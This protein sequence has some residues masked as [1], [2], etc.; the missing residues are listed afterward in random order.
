MIFPCISPRWPAGPAH[1][2]IRLFGALALQFSSAVAANSPAVVGPRVGDFEIHPALEIQLVAAEPLLASPV[3]MAFDEAGRLFVAEMRDYP[4]LNEKLLGR[5]SILEDT[6][7]DGRFDR[8]RVFADQLAWPSGIACYNG[9]VFVASTP[10]LIYL[11]DTDGDGRADVR[12][13]VF[14][15]FGKSVPTPGAD[16][17]FN[18]FAWGL[19]NRFYGST[20]ANGGRVLRAGTSD[21]PKE[22]K[23]LDFSFDP[24]ALTL[25][26]ETGTGQYGLTFDDFG[27]R[28]LTNN[29]RHLIMAM[30]DYRYATRNPHFDLPPALLDIPVDGPAAEVFRISPEEEWRVIRTQWRVAGKVVGMIEGGGRSSGY[31]TSACGV[32]IYR[33]DALPAEFYGNAFVAEPTGNLVHRKILSPNG[34]PMAGRRATGEEK[35]EVLRSRDQLFRPVAFANGP[36][37]ALYLIDMHRQLIEIAS[38]LPAGVREKVD[39]YGGRDTGRIYRIAARGRGPQRLP[40][41]ADRPTSDLVAL[42]EARNA[43]SRETAARLIFERQDRTAVAA[44]ERLAQRANQAGTRVLALSVLDGLGA[45]APKH[46]LPALADPQSEVRE[47]AVKLAERFAAAGAVIPAAVDL[48][49][50]LRTHLLRLADDPA[51][52]VRYQLAFSIGELEPGAD[53]DAALL[54]IAV[55]SRG[56]RWL[57][58]ACLTAMNRN[59]YTLFRRVIT[60]AL[61]LEQAAGVNLVAQMLGIL[62]SRGQPEERPAVIDFLAG[63]Q[64]E[65]TQMKLVSAYQAGLKRQNRL[66]READPEGK[67]AGVLVAAAAR[68][69]DVTADAA[70]RVTAIRLAALSPI[71]G[72][73]LF[74]ELLRPAEP[75]QIQAEAIAALALRPTPALAAELTRRWTEFTAPVRQQAL[76]LLIAQPARMLVLLDAVRQ[77]KIQRSDLTASQIQYLKNH[78]DRQVQAEA[79]AVFAATAGNRQAV[80]DRFQGA[81]TLT[82]DFARGREVFRTQCIACHRLEGVG[83]DLGTDLRGV[84]NRGKEGILI[85]ILDPNRKVD[86]TYLFYEIVTRKGDVV[87]GAVVDETPA[88]ITIRQPQGDQTV[89]M[90]A[91]LKSMKANAQSLM[92]EGLE[93]AISVQDM[94]D[95]LEY[96][97]HVP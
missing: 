30:Y 85:D 87:M 12:K 33:G 95:L 53:A 77:Q 83:V 72:N 48:R 8:S 11:R 49:Q 67:L 25:R 61:L 35:T 59:A 36:D 97:L 14:T 65:P 45:L 22:M 60:D 70:V 40:N 47:F 76:K 52:R 37:G 39:V 57:E 17:V 3:A 28:Y 68:A 2:A 21:S 80:I 56:D 5:I 34:V 19:D 32:T 15:G 96:V 38:A 7:G 86:P 31:F 44:V 20:S 93:A 82:P 64:P 84:R 92:P 46:L 51:E 74:Y 79:A 9:G 91:E 58:A 10:D 23:G 66:L 69:R 94:A 50:E 26:P 75:Q 42:L 62:G 27:R 16:M 41:L 78:P 55:R 81:L 6:D 4:D 63:V 43:W 90:R 24:V 89:L 73:D 54:R 29:S 88:S 13:V 71:A 1:G 18:G